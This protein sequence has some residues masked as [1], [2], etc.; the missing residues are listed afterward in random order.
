[1][2]FDA[3]PAHTWSGATPEAP[4]LLVRHDYLPDYERQLRLHLPANWAAFSTF[5]ADT[6]RLLTLARMLRDHFPGSRKRVLNIGSGPFATEL[7]VAPLQR[8]AIYSFDYTPEFAQFFNIFRRQGLLATTLFMRANALTIEFAPHSFDLIIMHDILYEKALDLG[9]LLDHHQRF[10]APGGMLY[11]DFMNRQTQWLWRLLGKERDYRR[12]GIAEV[13]GLLHS[14]GFEVIERAHA[15]GR[16]GRWT[17][18]FHLALQRLL[19]TSNTIAVLA[20]KNPAAS[21]N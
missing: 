17:S 13:E 15:T 1:M 7:F 21:A 4:P 8:H 18:L 9:A 19:R 12:Y 16:S 2:S 10:L 11:L 3:T 20:I 14:K 5:F 6:H